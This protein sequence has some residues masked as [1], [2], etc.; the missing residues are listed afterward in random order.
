VGNHDGTYKGKRYFNAAAEFHGAFVRVK[1]VLYAKGRR[2]FSYRYACM[3]VCMY[4][5]YA[6]GRE[7][8]VT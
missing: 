7:W 1:D 8:R 2:D 6:V 4:V 5:L 3:H